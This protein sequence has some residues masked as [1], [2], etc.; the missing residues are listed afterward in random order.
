MGERTGFFTEQ[1]KGRSMKDLFGNEFK[2]DIRNNSGKKLFNPCI[3]VFGQGPEGARCKTCEHLYVKQYAGRYFK[4]D[5][6][7]NSNGPATDHK[8]NWPACGKYK[9]QES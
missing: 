2:P 5:L 3:A 6:R 1:I 9:R 7:R 4:C 8:A